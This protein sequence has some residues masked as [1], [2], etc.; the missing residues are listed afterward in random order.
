M[1]QPNY[2]RNCMRKVAV[3]DIYYTENANRVYVLDAGN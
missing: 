1:T 2:M 3:N